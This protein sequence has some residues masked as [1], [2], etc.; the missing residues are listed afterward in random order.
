MCL[1]Q[2]WF[3]WATCLGVGLL[4]HMVVL[5]PV[6]QGLSIQ[7][8]TVAVSIYIPFCSN[9]KMF[10][11]LHTLS[12]IYCLRLFHDGHSDWCEVVSHC[13]FDLHF[14]NN[15]WFWT[16]FHVLFDH[17]Y[18]LFREMSVQVFCLFLSGCLHY[19]EVWYL[20]SIWE[21]CPIFQFLLFISSLILLWSM[22]RHC[23][24]SIL[25]N[26]LCFNLLCFLAQTGLPW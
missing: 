3:P 23:I 21:G 19:L 11:F 13:S 8:S 17:L 2:F 1:F 10:P 25:L 5:F 18:V 20:I 15:Q 24:I 12:S 6:F 26:L 4:G 22:S 9:A 16:S 7:S 14:S